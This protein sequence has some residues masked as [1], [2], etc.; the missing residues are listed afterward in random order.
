M[1]KKRQLRKVGMALWWR[2]A[3]ASTKQLLFSSPQSVFKTWLE[4]SNKGVISS[5][6]D[7]YRKEL[8]RTP[9]EKMFLL[10]DL[11]IWI[12]TRGFVDRR[13]AG[14]GASS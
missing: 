4:C 7:W 3:L 14:R 8:S 11:D 1:Q 9:D 12:E 6:L 10:C 13:A 2:Y 5:G